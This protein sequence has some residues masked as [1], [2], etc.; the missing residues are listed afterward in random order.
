MS[1]EH[2]PSFEEVPREESFETMRPVAPAESAEP[3]EAG[4]FSRD[5][6]LDSTVASLETAGNAVEETL[7]SLHWPE[8]DVFS[9]SLAVREALANIMI[10]Q[11]LDRHHKEGERQEDYTDG[12]LAAMQEEGSSKP[13]SMTIEVHGDDVIVDM[14]GMGDYVMRTDEQVDP[15]TKEKVFLPHGRGQL[16]IFNGCDQLIAYPG[17]LALV[18]RRSDSRS[19]APT[20]FSSESQESHA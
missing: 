10:H 4:G 19:Q 14:R 11:N 3:V 15:A 18:K 17:G 2:F 7:E 9:Y 5:F 12:Y 13:V 20:P 6:T 8:D 16:L 1:A